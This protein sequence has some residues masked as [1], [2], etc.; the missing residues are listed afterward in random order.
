MADIGSKHCFPWKKTIYISSKKNMLTP[1]KK[2]LAEIILCFSTR[3]LTPVCCWFIYPTFHVG[4]EDELQDDGESVTW[5]GE[6][7]GMGLPG[8]WGSCCKDD[9]SIM[10]DVKDGLVSKFKV[11]IVSDSYCKSKLGTLTDRT[12]VLYQPQSIYLL[13]IHILSFFFAIFVR[14]NSK[15]IFFHDFISQAFCLDETPVRFESTCVCDHPPRG[16]SLLQ[17][18]RW[19]RSRWSWIV[20]RT[21]RQNGK[22]VSFLEGH[23]F[24]KEI[25]IHF[26]GGFSSQL[27]S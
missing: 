25:R 1:P 11:H 12:E 20:G 21:L 22:A 27:G 23:F 15:R 24:L 14:N 8:C 17:V 5:H 6:W 2:W 7:L 3:R 13:H 18:R 10:N 26:Q 9:F 16:S 4:R 19:D